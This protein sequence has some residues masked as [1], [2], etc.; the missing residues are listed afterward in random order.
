MKLK[1]GN[2][3]SQFYKGWNISQPGCSKLIRRFVMSLGTTVGSERSDLGSN[4]FNSS[5]KRDQCFRPYLLFCKEKKKEYSET[6]KKYTVDELR[7]CFDSLEEY[8]RIIYE[9]RSEALLARGS[10][11][12]QEV[13]DIIKSTNGFIT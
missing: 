7:K 13:I 11:L 3:F 5:K 8:E 9:T 2:T 6:N 4:I 12:G 1:N 10:Y